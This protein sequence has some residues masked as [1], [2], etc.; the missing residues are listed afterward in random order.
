MHRLV[1]RTVECSFKGDSEQ[2]ISCAGQLHTWIR[3]GWTIWS[4]PVCVCVACQMT[5]RC[6]IA[7]VI[8]PLIISSVIVIIIYCFGFAWARLRLYNTVLL[9][10][11]FSCCVASP[12]KLCYC[13]PF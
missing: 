13:A 4:T 11:S 10:F 7:R 3:N 2:V 6:N 12:G 9:C 1:H 5:I 8:Y